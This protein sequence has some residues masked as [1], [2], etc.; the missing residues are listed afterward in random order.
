MAYGIT[1]QGCIIKTLDIIESELISQYQAAFGQQINL[2]PASVFSQI[3]RIAAEREAN[4]WELYEAIYYSQYPNSAQ[5]I[6]LD[7]AV[8]IN[9]LVRKPAT[10]SISSQQ[11][12]RA[13]APNV[14]IPSF[15][16]I[17][18]SDNSNLVYQTLT[19]LTTGYDT[20]YDNSHCEVH[21][22]QFYP[23]PQS[24]DFAIFYGSGFA[25]G[26]VYDASAATVQSAINGATAMGITVTVGGNSTTGY[27]VK[28]ITPSVSTSNGLSTFTVSTS[29]LLDGSGNPVS[30]KIVF[31]QFGGYVAIGTAQALN[32]GDSYI[33]SYNTL[34]QLQTPI[35]QITATFNTLDASIGRNQESDT[36]LRIR[37]NT[38]LALPGS[39][40][41][42]AIRSSILTLNDIQYCLVAVNNTMATDPENR[43]PKSIE[44][45]VSALDKTDLDPLTGPNTEKV[46]ELRQAVAE[47]IFAD[48]AAGIEVYGTGN[49]M[50]TVYDSMNRAVI[51]PFSQP[52]R[53][54]I[55]ANI[56]VQKNNKYPANGD[57]LVQEAILKYGASLG[58]GDEVI[59]YPDM[60]SSLQGIPGIVDIATQIDTSPITIST[61]D[62]SIPIGNGT[63]DP[64]N[65][66]ATAYKVQI[67]IW[68]SANIV[69][70]S[71]T[72]AV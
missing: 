35:S 4:L 14:L 12:F 49:I 26:L 16:R 39:S 13:S 66:G 34:T 29:N 55:Y 57:T 62:A 8:G 61:G 24:G 32:P 54:P 37:R 41:A 27:D 70:T 20:R 59:V 48:A 69:V 1:D 30:Y 9:G 52:E 19:D 15:T 67:S 31:K 71:T 60:I 50:E 10:Y 46:Q 40:T 36:E 47:A 6:S 5:G 7:Y 28:F 17:V 53:V 43:P 11:I 3:I 23:E 45:Y 25:T 44:V 51:I 58:V 68:E 2:L 56:T 22:I 18:N 72:S 65:T 63:N 33:G 42:D 64:P 38:E 21:S